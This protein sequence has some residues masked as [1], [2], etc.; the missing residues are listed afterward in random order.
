MLGRP[1]ALAFVL[2]LLLA[3]AASAFSSAS[4]ELTI[5]YAVGGTPTMIATGALFLDGTVGTGLIIAGSSG[6]S[7]DRIPDLRIVDRSA[8]LE[9]RTAIPGATLIVEAG[10]MLWTFPNGSTAS[11]A[12][13]ERYAIAVAL[14]QAPIPVEG[15]AAPPAGFL[16]ASEEVN[17]TVAWTRG[18]AALL[19]LDAIITI[20]DARGRPLPGWDSRRVNQ[21]VTAQQDPDSVDFVF[22]ANGAFT[23][24][25]ASTIL[26]GASAGSEALRLVIGPAEEDRFAQTAEAFRSATSSIFGQD[27]PLEGAQ[28]P[29]D[30]LRPASGVL[31]GALVLVPA[32]AGG[33]G[34]APVLLESSFGAAEFP[35][36]PFNLVRGDD[37]ELSWTSERMTLSGTPTV[38]LGRDGFG[39]DEPVAVGIFPILS[40]L[41]WLVAIGAIVYFFVRRPEKAKGP[42]VLRL[43]SFGVYVLALVVVFLFWDRSF[44]Q[45]F[46]TGVVSTIQTQGITGD[47]LPQIGILAMLELVP[48]SI[49]ALLFALPVRIAAGVGLRYLGKGKS[50]KGV[51][52]AAGLVSLAIF[53]P[54]Y[55]LWCFNLVWA[56]AAEMMPNVAGG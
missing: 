30:L 47:S 37:M 31:N 52:T 26:G 18:E 44:E 51:A 5:A 28:D 41:L 48:W 20:E 46:G 38:A 7:F 33:E 35:L 39:V 36:G 1:A 17:G 56:R 19:P 13:S 12:T 22:L 11:I 15:G 16:L 9:A 29:L 23:A 27:S 55:A 53:G 32:A 8:P 54:I 49:A 40:V 21:G 43:A 3:P 25:I 42:F 2:T 34:P 10:A 45:T 14:P 4:E 50:L 6:T 24:R